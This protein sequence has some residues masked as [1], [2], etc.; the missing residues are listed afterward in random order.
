MDEAKL[1]AF[2]D[3]QARLQRTALR[4]AV[5]GPKGYSTSW[6][7][8]KRG[9]DYYIGARGLMGAQKISIIKATARS[10]IRLASVRQ[11]NTGVL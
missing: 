9:N 1:A 11:L 8:F 10:K 2:E 6:T 5:C 4:F 3:L 7:A